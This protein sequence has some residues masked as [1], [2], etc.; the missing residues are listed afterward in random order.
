VRRA[1]TPWVAAALG[2]LA[3]ASLLPVARPH[4]FVAPGEGVSFLGRGTLVLLV[5]LGLLVRSR[6]TW[7]LALALAAFGG[8]AAL[9]YGILAGTHVVAWALLAA[10]CMTALG[11]LAWPG[12][13]RGHYG[14]NVVEG[15]ASQG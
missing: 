9:A 2:C 10:L 1:A 11:L 4:W 12:A 8:A 3:L 7:W 13:V 5:A 14:R 6:W 15:S